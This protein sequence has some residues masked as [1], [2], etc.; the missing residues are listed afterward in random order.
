MTRS[1]ASSRTWPA[2]PADLGQRGDALT[3]HPRVGVG[4]DRGDDSDQVVA[5]HER[6][7]R[8]VVVLTTAHLLF[9]ERDPGRF[10]AHHRLTGP[11]RGELAA[12]EKWWAD[13]VTE[14]E[15]ARYPDHL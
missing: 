5:W 2:P 12:Y 9:G 10:D 14:W 7:G 8:L 3:N 15:L 1:A 13:S 4:A 6:E 11:R